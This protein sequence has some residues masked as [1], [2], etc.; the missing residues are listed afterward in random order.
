MSKLPP[1]E[2]QPARVTMPTGRTLLQGRPY[3]PSAATDLRQSFAAMAVAER[4]ER[5]IAT[6]FAERATAPMD[7]VI[8]A[9]RTLQ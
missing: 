5:L 8:P 1:L 9:P 7:A 2:R 3:T 4:V 6:I